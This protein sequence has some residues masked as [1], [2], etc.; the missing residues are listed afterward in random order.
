MNKSIINNKLVQEVLC[1][2]C[3]QS[4]KREN[5]KKKNV[6]VFFT[7][8]FMDFDYEYGGHGR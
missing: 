8:I 1:G 3:R 4:I 6:Q 5:G 2:S 7:S